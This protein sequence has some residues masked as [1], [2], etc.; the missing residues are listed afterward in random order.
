M[1]GGW[2]ADERYMSMLKKLRDIRTES[3]DLP[4]KPAA[5]VAIFVDEN[6]YFGFESMDIPGKISLVRRQLGKAGAPYEL[7]IAQDV[8][9]V[10]DKYKAVL[11]LNPANTPD[12]LKVI[13]LAEDKGVACFN[14]TAENADI[15]TAS[16]REFLRDAGVH[17]YCEN[18][19]VIYANESF[20]FLHTCSN[21]A[22]KI[23]MKSDVTLTDVLTGEEFDGSTERKKGQSFILRINKK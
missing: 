10:I 5:E 3:R 12:S 16:L 11:I 17:I 21:G 19:A 22:Y 4:S 13:E 14:V 1:W 18:D 6:S 2:Y 8:E 15:P 7:Y 23:N 9:K 20:V